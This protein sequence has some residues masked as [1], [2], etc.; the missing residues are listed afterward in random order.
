MSAFPAL[1]DF[2]GDDG[3]C[4]SSAVAKYGKFWFSVYNNKTCYGLITSP[5]LKFEDAKNFCEKSNGTLA[6]PKSPKLN[7]Y[8]LKFINDMDPTYMPWLG[9]RKKNKDYFFLD[10]SK[11]NRQVLDHSLAQIL[12]SP[13]CV[14]FSKGSGDWRQFD[15]DTELNYLCEW[16]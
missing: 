3:P 10:D 16:N 12:S 14:I 11:S 9:I 1:G 7:D 6:M 2:L 5:K 4:P 8:L 15:C 13:F